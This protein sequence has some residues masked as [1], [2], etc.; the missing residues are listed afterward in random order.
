[1]NF[2]AMLFL[3]FFW[4]WTNHNG[5]C[6]IIYVF[7]ILIDHLLYIHQKHAF[8]R[9]NHLSCAGCPNCTSSH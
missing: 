5:D 2:T 1:M 4:L 6:C 3:F 7:E 9:R 8:I